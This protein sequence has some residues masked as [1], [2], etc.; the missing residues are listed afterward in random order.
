M[1]MRLPQLAVTAAEK[2]AN[3]PCGGVGCY[4]V[5]LAVAIDIREDKRCWMVACR[6]IHPCRE[7]AIPKAERDCDFPGIPVSGDQIQLAI[8]IQVADRHA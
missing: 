5:K 7:A 6:V 4:Q 3:G 8:A 2:Y 1:D